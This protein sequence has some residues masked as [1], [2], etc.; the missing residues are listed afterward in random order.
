MAEHPSQ[1]SISRQILVQVLVSNV[2]RRVVCRVLI[3]QLQV[4]SNG[5]RLG[6]QTHPSANLSLNSDPEL[7][8]GKQTRFELKKS[9]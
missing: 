3:Q 6:T 7:L 8:Q 4:E 5:L 1:I 2:L 9:S